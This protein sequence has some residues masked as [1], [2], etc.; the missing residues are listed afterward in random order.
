[1]GNIGGV[2]MYDYI[3]GT[4]QGIF[5]DYVTIENHGIGYKIYSSGHTM[6]QMPAMGQ[7]TVLYLTQNHPGGF[8]GALWLHV[9][10]GAGSV[11]LLSR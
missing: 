3:R 4:Y 8:C 1:M 5:K 11:S 7:E 10:G 6:A 9:S 2:E